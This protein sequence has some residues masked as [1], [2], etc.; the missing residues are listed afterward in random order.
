MSSP[1]CVNDKPKTTW[2][3]RSDFGWHVNK[4]VA[5]ALAQVIRCKFKK[6]SRAVE[7]TKDTTGGPITHWAVSHN[8]KITL[9]ELN[10]LR[11][12][13]DGLKLANYGDEE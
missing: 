12:H 13:C 2:R 4:K 3:Y 9:A 1:S 10:Y 8:K 7:V 6:I 11:G 5:E